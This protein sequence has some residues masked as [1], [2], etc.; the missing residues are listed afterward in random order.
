[1]T[2]ATF[3][4]VIDQTLLK[5]AAEKA[6]R[7]IP[8]L[9]PL[10]SSVAVNPFLGQVDETLADVAARLGRIAGI[11][12]TMPRRWYAAKIAKGEV[13]DDD[14]AAALVRAPVALRSIDA[15]ILKKA[16]LESVPPIMPLPTVAVWCQPVAG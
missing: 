4:T 3:A 14:L 5:E 12:V 9:W 7:A 2:Q 13:T 15:A 16:V 10:A 6:A 11:E 8:P 1:M